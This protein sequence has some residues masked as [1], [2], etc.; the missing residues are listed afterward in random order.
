MGTEGTTM[1]PITQYARVRAL[2][3]Q[4][5]AEQYAPLVKRIAN[6]LLGRV[7][8]T[9]PAEDLIQCGMIRLLEAARDYDSSRDASFETYASVRIRG[10][11]L[12]EVRGH[13]WAPRSVHK[14][15]REIAGA[16]REI[17]AATG[18][19]AT[20][21]EIAERLEISLDDYYL[22]LDSVSRGQLL[23]LDEMLTGD[24]PSEPS[25]SE[26]SPPDA[27]QA[28]HLSE[29]LAEAI[30]TL[31]EREQLLVSLYYVDELNFK[32][33]GS[34]LGVGES[35]ISQIHTQL[36]LRLRASLAEWTRG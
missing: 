29:R 17:Q 12:D 26:V 20:S 28:A 9:V 33:I 4:E 31:P 5:L 30:T 25:S 18:Q 27:V 16:M 2:S 14:R 32:E 7:P 6:H 1:G 24:L 22:A 36:L 35:R 15:A 21:R 34:V 8:Q 13:A 3:G 19:A 11:M 23:S 10:A